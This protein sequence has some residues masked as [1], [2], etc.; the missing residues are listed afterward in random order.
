MIGLNPN[1]IIESR[2][3]HASDSKADALLRFVHLV[4]DSN[5]KINDSDLHQFRAEGYSDGEVAE[6]IAHISLSVLTNFFNN[7]AKTEIDFPEVE[8]IAV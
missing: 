4:L 5:G 6:V 1:Q 3:G 2:T 7:V 8:A